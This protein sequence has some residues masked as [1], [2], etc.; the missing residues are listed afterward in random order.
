VL[1]DTSSVSLS[2]R[3]TSGRHALLKCLVSP[4]SRAWRLRCN[5]R[6]LKRTLRRRLCNALITRKHI[7]LAWRR[8]KQI[9]R[10]AAG[11][12]RASRMVFVSLI[13]SLEK[14][15]GATRTPCRNTS[16]LS[17]SHNK[18]NS[19]KECNLLP[20]A[21]LVIIRWL[22]TVQPGQSVVASSCPTSVVNARNQCVAY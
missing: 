6:F 9:P 18:A 7:N 11:R 5:G 13:P 22:I 19:S 14:A 8:Q 10:I 1:P 17:A 3:G 16:C 15:A 4:E 2:A 12:R 20:V 21:N